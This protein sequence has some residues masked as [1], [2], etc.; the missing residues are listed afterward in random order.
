MNL[1]GNG[2]LFVRSVFM[3]AI[4]LTLKLPAPAMTFNVTF[5]SS[6]TGLANAAQVET[7]FSNATQVFQ[8][9]YTNAMTVNITVFYIGGV[10]LGQ[11]IT[12]EIG[13]P[14]YTNLT[15]ALLATRTTA[16][17]SNSVASLPV[18]DPTPNSSAGTNW[19]IARAESKALN[20]LPPPCNVGTNSSS[21][22]GQVYFDSGKIYTFDP[23]NRAVSG[24][25][26]FIGVAEHEISEVLGRG[27]GLNL[28]NG[29]YIPYDLFRFISSSVHTINTNDTGVYFSVD[30]GVTS[31]KTFN[32]NG[33]S[34]DLQDW[35]QESPADSYDAF[36]TSGQKAFL[37]SADLTALNILGYKLNL[38]TPRLAATRSGSTNILL[39]FTNVSGLNFSILAST[40]IATAVTNWSVL[41][42]P[43]EAPTAGQYQF[44]DS[45]TNKTRFYR[46]RLN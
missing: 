33:N 46:V 12:D 16:A 39:T 3:V 5:D 1:S 21:E 2:K 30:D 27:S 25:F 17:D 45:I 35:L 4:L 20:I 18:N 26:D 37:S 9:L 42:S 36:L 6:V 34:G 7:S 44:T 41:G 15:L 38:T 28:H 11:S 29:G 8:N 22:D 19:W 23:T 24:K 10:G 43:I 31:L 14:V 13:H 32:T 40:N